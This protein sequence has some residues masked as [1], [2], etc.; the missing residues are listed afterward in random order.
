MQ[1]THFDTK[2]I[3]ETERLAVGRMEILLQAIN[4]V[5]N[6]SLVARMQNETHRD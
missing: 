6:P 1:Y 5:A 3:R 4:S 2:E